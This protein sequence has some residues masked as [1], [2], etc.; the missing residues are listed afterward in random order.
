[1]FWRGA[2]IL[3]IDE[4]IQ[5]MFYMMC[6]SFVRN[7]WLYVN[8]LIHKE[9][10]VT[11]V[12]KGCVYSLWMNQFRY[13]QAFRTN[14]PH[15][16]IRPESHIWISPES[17]IWMSTLYTS[18][19]VYEWVKVCRWA[20]V[21]GV[22]VLMFWRGAYIVMINA[23]AMSHVTR[24]FFRTN[25]SHIWV[26]PESHMWMSTRYVEAHMWMDECLRI[27]IWEW[28]LDL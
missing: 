10:H 9:G 4:S 16:W 1:M 3:F 11:H 13:N 12:L 28:V 23:W 2:C 14:E 7:A 25:N 20:R 15:I 26:S 22:V 6:G 8:W 5:N 18:S 17:H 19:H 27:H 24:H 21:N